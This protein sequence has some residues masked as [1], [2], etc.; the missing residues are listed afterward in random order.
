MGWTSGFAEVAGGRLAF[1]R[2]GG[3]GPALVLS[4]GLTDNGL[5]WSR[6]ARAL[7]PDFDVI[8][9]DARGHG[10]SSRRAAGERPNPGQDIADA[11]RSLGLTRPLLMG[12][13][14]GARATAQFAAV[15]PDQVSKVILEDPPLIP[16]IEA[17]KLAARQAGF[18]DHVAAFQAMSEAE[19]TAKGKAD[20]PL[21]H[22]DEFPAW[23]ASKRQ[24]DPEAFPLYTLPWQ[25]AVAGI[26]APTLLIRGDAERGSLVTPER[27]EAAMALNARIETVHI[28]GAGHNIRR[29]NFADMLAAVRA[30]LLRAA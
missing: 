5:C 25:D 28:R 19:I 26:K 3:A 29:E 30:F 20:S 12:H 4:H 11:I 15:F 8:M 1:H 10:E 6:M 21:W 17:S 23:A 7:A 18:R 16:L 22:D 14:V 9:L 27:A 13:S 2:T 24:V